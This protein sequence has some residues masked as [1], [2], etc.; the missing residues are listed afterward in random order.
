M[1][2]ADGAGELSEG[3]LMR[4]FFTVHPGEFLVGDYITRNLPY[5][6]WVPAKDAGIDLLLTP[7]KIKSCDQASS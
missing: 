6:V 4:A 3:R 1:F 2:A 5:D 7:P